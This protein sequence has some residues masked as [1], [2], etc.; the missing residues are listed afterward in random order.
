MKFN[1]EYIFYYTEN[2]NGLYPEDTDQN[3]IE[4]CQDDWIDMNSVRGYGDYHQTNDIYDLIKQ[5]EQAKVKRIEI[6]SNGYDIRNWENK[7]TGRQY[8][9]WY[10]DSSCCDIEDIDE[11]IETL[12]E[13]SLQVA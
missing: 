6:D 10:Y 9:E 11:L 7:I 8:Q 2:N 3:S 12:K 1:F 13:Q 4:F 5:L